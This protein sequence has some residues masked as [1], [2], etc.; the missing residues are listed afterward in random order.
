V[1]TA[2][3]SSGGGGGRA[4]AS[5][6]RDEEPVPPSD[7]SSDASTS[8]RQPIS[9]RQGGSGSS[10][11]FR[12]TSPVRI[13]ETIV[14]AQ[15]LLSPTT[16]AAAAAVYRAHHPPA[17]TSDGAGGTARHS[18]PYRGV[19]EPIR[20]GGASARLPSQ[21]DYSSFQFS[22]RD[23]SP[24]REAKTPYQPLARPRTPAIREWSSDKARAVSPP[25]DA[26]TP[27]VPLARPVAASE[28]RITPPMAQRPG[29]P[30]KESNG[31]DT[32][33]SAF[34][35]LKKAS[36]WMSLGV[37][38]VPRTID[39][40]GSDRGGR[41]SHRQASYRRAAE[42]AARR[43]EAKLPPNMGFADPQTTVRSLEATQRARQA[44]AGREPSAAMLSKLVAD[45]KAG[46]ELLNPTCLEMYLSDAEFQLTFQMGKDA[47]YEL[48]QWKQRELKKR[49][50]LF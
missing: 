9:G 16:T 25:R 41:K 36:P 6:S 7:A 50:G 43:A 24:P 4:E 28:R 47:F 13:M 3:S 5:P 8:S 1:A 32:K 18:P 49:A 42:A 17:S 35:P 21:R 19:A 23:W 11:P 38:N 31:K 48:K 10:R 37:E 45:G 39:M 20:V 44:Y 15:P 40:Q 46:E 2:A 22:S 27:Y 33:P 29:S 12:S 30:P 34:T 14:P 26:V